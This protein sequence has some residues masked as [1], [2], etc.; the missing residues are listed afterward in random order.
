MA[1]PNPYLYILARNDL[2][3]L[4]PGKLAAQ[5]CHAANICQTVITD[6]RLA[7]T[8]RGDKLA[9]LWKTW[10]GDRG[11]GTTITLEV[12][13]IVLDKIKDA[14]GSHLFN[15]EDKRPVVFGVALDPG[16]PVCDGNITHLV[17]L[18]ACGFVFGDKNKFDVTSL[19]S[20]Y[21]L[22]P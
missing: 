19:T 7:G 10:A 16:Y 5:A 20:G 12:P 3:S 22:F 4:N 13:T 18:V 6:G 11:F 14:N 8:K 1:L 2:A 17:P 21:K 15:W 9:E